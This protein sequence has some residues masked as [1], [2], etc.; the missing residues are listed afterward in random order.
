MRISDWSS[1]VCSSDLDQAPGVVVQHRL[2]EGVGHPHR[3][4]GVLAGY[5]EVGVGIPIAVVGLE[6]DRG[7]ALL[8]ELHHAGDVVLRHQGGA[9]S[10]HRGAQREVALGIRSEEHTSELQSLMRISY[11]VFCLKKKI[12]NT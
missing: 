2:D 3:V 10:L 7:V 12:K 6:V 5:R 11:A 4:V 9:R 8:G 1:D